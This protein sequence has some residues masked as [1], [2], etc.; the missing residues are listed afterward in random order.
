[1]RYTWRAYY[2]VLFA[3]RCAYS[4][5]AQVLVSRLTD[6]SDAT[7]YQFGHL[8]QFNAILNDFSTSGSFLLQREATFLTKLIGAA[9]GLLVG[10]NAVLIN[11]CFQTLAFIGIVAFLRGLDPGPRRIAAVLVML[12]SFSLWSSVASKE[13][14]VVLAV[15]LLCRYVVDLHR[16]G[17]AGHFVAALSLAIVYLYKPHF[18]PALLFAIVLPM[19]ARRVSLPHTTVL[20]AGLTTLGLL[21]AVRQQLDDMGR[22][23]SRWMAAEPGASTRGAEF[24]LSQPND[25]FL[26]AP[27][28]MW[29]SFVGPTIGETGDGALHLLSYIESI[30]IVAV[31]L[32]YFI[33]KVPRMPVYSFTVAIFTLFWILLPTYPFGITNPGTAIRYRTDYLLIVYLAVLALP[34]R[35]LFLEGWGVA[36]APRRPRPTLEPAPAAVT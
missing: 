8:S 20:A 30:G 9:F 4:F 22:T 11:I 13:A 36:R 18:V 32:L 34:M 1:M 35:S 25:F 15:G 17:R 19:V 10:G 33:P 7:G 31:L 12:P 28:G 2:F 26:R 3:Y 23:I 27:S 29:R 21:Y 24:Y 14:V 5:L 6:M 16:G